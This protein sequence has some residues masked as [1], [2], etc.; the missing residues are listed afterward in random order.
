MAGEGSVGT[1]TVAGHTPALSRWPGR[2]T[3]S[4]LAPREDRED[5]SAPEAVALST[6]ERRYRRGW[7]AGSTLAVAGR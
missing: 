5:P 3:A 4:L 2:V 1:E 6:P 7:T